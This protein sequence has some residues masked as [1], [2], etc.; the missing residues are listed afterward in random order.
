MAGRR[1]SLIDQLAMAAALGEDFDFDSDDEESSS[2]EIFEDEVDRRSDQELVDS[3]YEA[4]RA[5]SMDSTDDP[6]TGANESVAAQIDTDLQTSHPAQAH[7][8]SKTSKTQSISPVPGEVVGRALHSS[9]PPFQVTAVGG[10]SVKSKEDLGSPPTA[11]VDTGTKVPVIVG[12]STLNSNRRQ[13]MMVQSIRPPGAVGEL[14]QS[15]K[16]QANSESEKAATSGTSVV[17][18]TPSNGNAV[19]RQIKKFAVGDTVLVLLAL[20]NV[21]N[22]DDSKDTFTVAPVNRMGF[23]QGEGRTD[24]E[25]MGPYKYVLA[26]VNHVHFDEDDRYYTIIRADTGTEQR[27][28]SGT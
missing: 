20:L 5:I 25:K 13:H 7:P 10:A 24:G 2:G 23:P 17:A 3:R 27:A 11:C 12:I 15:L 6:N 19:T 1:S 22:V 28:D 26:T 14:D 4:A 21:T 8:F 16:S 9:V 18:S